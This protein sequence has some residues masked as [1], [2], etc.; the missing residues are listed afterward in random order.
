MKTNGGGLK[1]DSM[2][3]GMLQFCLVGKS[4]AWIF[5]AKKNC[6]HTHTLS[7]TQCR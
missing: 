4:Q 5:S 7:H 6:E 3:H 1:C 2:R